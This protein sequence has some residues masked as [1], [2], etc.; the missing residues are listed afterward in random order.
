MNRHTLAVAA[1]ALA[2]ILPV[3][4]PETGTMRQTLDAV[5]LVED[6]FETADRLEAWVESN[7]GY[8]ISRLEEQLVLRVPSAALE[9]FVDFLESAADE[10]IQ[11]QQQSEDISQSLLEAEAGIRSKTDLFDKALTLIDQT[12]LATTLE[13]ESEVLSILTDLEALRGQ[14]R[15]LLG[16]VALARV[17]VDFRLQEEKLPENLPSSFAW[18]NAV[19]FYSFMREFG[20]Q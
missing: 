7:G 19:D 14:Y 1:F 3:A 6:R 16:E 10:L 13:M 15:K 8:L 18:I 5:A 11:V 9:R 12:D 20:Q 2:L 4:Y 17:Q